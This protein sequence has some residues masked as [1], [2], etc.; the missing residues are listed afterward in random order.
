MTSGTAQSGSDYS[1]RY[2]GSQLS[3]T[4]ERVQPLRSNTNSIRRRRDFDSINI[5]HQPQIERQTN[6]D[7]HDPFTSPHSSD[8]ST[9]PDS[10]RQRAHNGLLGLGGESSRRMTSGT[11]Q[12][13]SD[14][15]SRYGGSQLS[16]TSESVQPLRSNTNSIRRRRDVDSLQEQEMNELKVGVKRDEEFR[17]SC[18]ALVLRADISHLRIVESDSFK[19]LLENFNVGNTPAVTVTAETFH[20]F[21]MMLQLKKLKR[22]LAETERKRQLELQQQENVSN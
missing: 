21:L 22:T 2:D 17:K 5:D 1:S 8:D 19:A 14:Y 11:A 12:S 7:E 18:M 16:A 4:S 20:R 13:G 9:S 15:S 3:A 6:R 10:Q